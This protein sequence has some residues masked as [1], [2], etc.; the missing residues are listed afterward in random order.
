MKRMTCY[1]CKGKGHVSGDVCDVCGGL[2]HL[3][4]PAEPVPPL[5]PEDME[6]GPDRD[7]GPGA[8][9]GTD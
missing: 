3:P 7:Q 5:D 1:R 6:E 2:G 9:N 4:V 8:V